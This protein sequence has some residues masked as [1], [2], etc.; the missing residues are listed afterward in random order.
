MSL[1]ELMNVIKSRGE[2]KLVVEAK[3]SSGTLL[4][5]LEKL[6]VPSSK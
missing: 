2:D 4:G 5:I 6:M 1:I 3:E